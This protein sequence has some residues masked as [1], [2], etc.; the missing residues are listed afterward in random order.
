MLLH[1]PVR[2]NPVT[3]QYNL[4]WSKSNRSARCIEP[5][6]SVMVGSALEELTDRRPSEWEVSIRCEK[7]R[8]ESRQN[9][10]PWPR[11]LHG[12]AAHHSAIV[13]AC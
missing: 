4:S 1:Q 2:Q 7:S 6:I 3:N 10:R 12:R 5:A 9:P 13:A 11:V 8:G